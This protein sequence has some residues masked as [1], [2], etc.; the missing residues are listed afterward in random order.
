MLKII[1]GFIS[2]TDEKEIEK[3][4]TLITEKRYVTV[5]EEG[6][7][8]IE[9]TDLAVQFMEDLLNEGIIDMNE[10]NE[11]TQVDTIKFYIN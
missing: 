5:D 6:P 7:D 9:V 8:F 3:I 10:V 2:V 11:I 1:K 4:S